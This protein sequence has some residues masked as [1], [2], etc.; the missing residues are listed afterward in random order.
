ME[1]HPDFVGRWKVRSLF[2]SE[3][4]F[5]LEDFMGIQRSVAPSTL[6]DFTKAA[7]IAGYKLAF[8]EDPTEAL[9]AFSHLNDPPTVVIESPFEDTINGFLPFQ[10]QGFNALKNVDGGVAMW[11]TGTGKTVL[12]SALIAHHLQAGSFDY[13]IFVVKSANKVNTHRAVKRLVGIESVIMDGDKKARKRLH[14]HLRNVSEPTLIVTNYEKL[15]V[16]QSDFLPLFDSRLLVIWDEMP[17]KLKNR[18]SQLYHAVCKLLYRTTPPAVS[19]DKRRPA[20]LRQY[21]LSAT[22][23]ENDP[24]DWFNC[25]RLLDPRI[26][27]TVKDFRNEFVSSYSFFDPNTPESWHKLDKMGAMTE[28]IVHQVDKNDSDIACQ[29]PE[30]I[31]EPFYID[32]DAKDRAIYDQVSNLDIETLPAIMLCQMLCNAPEMVKDSAARRDIFDNLIEDWLEAG[33]D[34]DTL[35][36]A[37]GSEA[38]QIFFDLIGDE[39]TNERHTKLEK[40]RSLLIDDHPN[41]KVVLFTALSNTIFPILEKKLEEWGVRF[42]TYHGT[43][44]ERQH[45]YDAFTSDPSIRV[46]LSSDAGSDS[47]NLEQASV[48]I[49]YDLPWKHSTYIQRQ[50]RAHRVTS[51]FGT[52]IFYTLMMANSVEDRKWEVIQRKAKY[53]EGVFKGAIADASASARM[54]K[55]DL[56]YILRGN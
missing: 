27:G 47:I 54:T 22:P 36:K 53:H 43:N 44:S 41:D 46:F 12:A 33:A 25:V 31:E 28:H 20:T 39:L 50:N 51:E 48:V 29:F 4:F 45:V 32:W 2:D 23:I 18:S 5:L 56:L 30:V 9:D 1:P 38:A 35:P 49:H 55:A 21:M 15:R 13:A 16:D 34:P 11:S 3:P 42:V 8:L 24:E 14:T 26:Y 19:W 7:E 52:V 37:N 17:T 40:L 10:V 6:A